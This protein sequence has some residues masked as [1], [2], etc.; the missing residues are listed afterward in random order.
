M[1]FD[2]VAKNLIQNQT[3]SPSG[4]TDRLAVLDTLTK[5]GFSPS[6]IFD[7]LRHLYDTAEDDTTKRQVLDMMLKVHGLYANK[8]QDKVVPVININIKGDND[9]IFRMLCPQTQAA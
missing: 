8:E 5:A 7:E 2:L 6:D 9:K 1:T 3:K 4:P